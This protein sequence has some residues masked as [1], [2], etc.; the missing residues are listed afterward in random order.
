M[1]YYVA[2]QHPD[3]VLFLRERKSSSLQQF[4]EDAKE[5]EENI[6]ACKMLR[7]QARVEDIQAYE[8]E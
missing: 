4:F 6:R 5:L 2:A 7:Y 3:L 1:V 8:Q